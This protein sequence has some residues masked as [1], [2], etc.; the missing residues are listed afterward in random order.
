MNFEQS[1][2]IDESGS[3]VLNDECYVICAVVC[4][5]DDLEHDQSILERT[6]RDFRSGA[7]LKSSAIG[8]NLKRRTDICTELAK[9]KSKCIVTVIQKKHLRRDGGF[10][11]KTSAYKY[12]QRRLFEKIYLGFNKT[13]VYVDTFGNEEFMD[14]FKSYIEKHF[15]PSIFNTDRRLNHATPQDEVM[16]QIADFVGGTVRR[17]IQGDDDSRAFDIL[18]PIY[19]LIEVWPRSP[20]NQRIDDDADELDIAIEQHCTNVAMELIENEEDVILK[21][22]MQFLLYA[23]PIETG[24]SFILGDRIL[25]FLQDQS[26]IDETKDKAWIQHHVIAPLR[27]KG[28]PIAAS[29]DGYKVPRNRNDLKLFVDFV[30]QKTLPYLQKVNNMRNSLSQGLGQQYDMLDENDDLKALM[31]SLSQNIG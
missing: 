24:G 16:L 1:I 27:D 13:N 2:F 14:G 30:S 6:R 21:E 9:L 7:E 29:R 26:L 19:S 3:P 18:R 23:A 8:S 22:A 5:N 28:A 17:H 10:S 11:Y 4:N 15:E 12:C 25:R 20:K 31:T